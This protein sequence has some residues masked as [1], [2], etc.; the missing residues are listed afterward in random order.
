MTTATND[1]NELKSVILYNSEIMLLRSAIERDISN[2]RK[3]VKTLRNLITE[4]QLDKND[5]SDLSAEYSLVNRKL[6]GSIDLFLIINKV[7][8]EVSEQLYNELDSKKSN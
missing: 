3:E 8:N 6:M 1:R 2:L 7:A 5:Y 4:K